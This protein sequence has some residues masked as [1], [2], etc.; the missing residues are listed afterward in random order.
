MTLNQFKDS[1]RC[2]ETRKANI[3]QDYCDW[4]Y[5]DIHLFHERINGPMRRLN[6]KS[7]P[8]QL[9]HFLNANHDSS[10][11]SETTYTDLDLAK[12]DAKRYNAIVQEGWYCEAP[13]L[14][15]F[16]IFKDL[17]QAI[18]QAYNELKKVDRV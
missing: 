11:W 9:F 7:T 8:A 3:S 17:D 5:N 14:H 4:Y 10:Y 15:W 6:F 16:L 13:D 12:S 1:V 2:S 18:E